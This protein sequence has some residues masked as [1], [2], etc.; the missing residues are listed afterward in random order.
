MSYTNEQYNED[1][2]KSRA[3]A[4]DNRPVNPGSKNK[5]E[6][7]KGGG[8]RKKTLNPFAMLGQ[9]D[10]LKDAPYACICIAT[11]LKEILD[12]VFNL[13]AALYPLAIVSSIL[14]GIFGIMMMQLAKFSEKIEKTHNRFVVKQF[15]KMAIWIL[16]NLFDSFPGLGVFP[17]SIVTTLIVY[18]MTLYERVNTEKTEKAGA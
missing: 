1:L 4:E 14:N 6:I 16:G 11:T 10:I 12:V 15:L 5:K 13:A 17:I 2:K 3:R 7:K 18:S 8:S 9:I